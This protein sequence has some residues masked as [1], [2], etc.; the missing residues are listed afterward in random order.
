MIVLC[1]ISTQYGVLD[2]CQLNGT[3]IMELN[4][5]M[6]KFNQIFRPG[7]LEEILAVED[8]QKRFVHYTSAD[9]AFKLLRN[10]ELWFRNAT[11]MNDFSEIS[12][13]LG[14]IRTV[15]PGPEGQRFRETI[16]DISPGT[17]EAAD[18][19]FSGWESDWQLETY[20]ACVS[21]HKPEEDQ[22]GRLSMWRAYGDT[23]LVINNTPMTAITDLLAVYSI[24]VRYLC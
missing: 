3:K 22:R 5:A 1:F 18:K 16:E 19:L 4:E 13:G 17:I 7:L 14:L 6:L 20:L 15:F 10:H 24:P 11:V 23:A 2:L 21:I 12:Y 9:T 8:E